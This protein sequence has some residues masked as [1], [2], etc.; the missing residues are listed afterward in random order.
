MM[1][2]HDRGT[3]PSRSSSLASECAEPAFLKAAC[4][5][6][7]GS[8]PRAGLEPAT[9]GLGGR[10]SGLLASSAGALTPRAMYLDG[11]SYKLETQALLQAHHFIAPSSSAPHAERK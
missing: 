2:A 9:R 8:T 5:L 7:S 6:G 1:I 11:G 10:L 3:S 4:G